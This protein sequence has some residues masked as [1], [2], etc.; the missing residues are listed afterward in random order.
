MAAVFVVRDE[1]RLDRL[2]KA[3]LGSERGGG[4]EAVLEANPGLGAGGPF[5]PFGTRLTVPAT[6]VAPDAPKGPQRPWE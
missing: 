1:E 4:L 2:A 3:M 5:A 6:V